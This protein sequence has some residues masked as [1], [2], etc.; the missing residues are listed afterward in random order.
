M[1]VAADPE[2]FPAAPIRADVLPAIA[3]PDTPEEGLEEGLTVGS[4]LGLRLG[5]RLAKS[6][7]PD[8]PP[9]GIEEVAG[10][11]PA[12]GK[13]FPGEAAGGLAAWA[14]GLPPGLSPVNGLPPLGGAAAEEAK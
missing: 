14:G 4:P 3:P 5:G 6:I 13:L 7:D 9:P 12:L 8:A 11:V 1:G 2:P 10:T